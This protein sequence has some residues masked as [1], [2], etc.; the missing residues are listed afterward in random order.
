MLRIT[1]ASTRAADRVVNGFWHQ[2]RRPGDAERYPN[3]RHLFNEGEYADA[4]R[5]SC[6]CVLHFSTGAWG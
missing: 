4:I 1:S 6:D 2:S 3:E 5:F